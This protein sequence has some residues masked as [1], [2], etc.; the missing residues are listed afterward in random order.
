ML[1]RLE[2]HD[3]L[4]NEV[5]LF[6]GEI[7]KSVIR[8]WLSVQGDRHL[9]EHGLQSGALFLKHVVVILENLDQLLV[10]LDLLAVVQLDLLNWL[11]EIGW[12]VAVVL[13][14]RVLS[15]DSF[16]LV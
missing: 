14:L 5:D 2:L 8:S 3:E 10:V 9:F 6:L 4:I 16:S 12:Q 11:T 1:S 13:K 15:N 7:L